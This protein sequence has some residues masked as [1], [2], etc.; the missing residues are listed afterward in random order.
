MD[1]ERR[2]ASRRGIN[3]FS[4]PRKVL[5]YFIVS[6]TKALVPVTTLSNDNPGQAAGCVKPAVL[7]GTLDF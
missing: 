1:L 7:A 5:E 3:Q 6:Q 4:C 2:Q